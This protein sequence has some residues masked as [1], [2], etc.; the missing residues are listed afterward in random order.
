MLDNR[1][2]PKQSLDGGWAT[3][4]SQ[5]EAVVKTQS[6]NVF[7]CLGTAVAGFQKAHEISC[8]WRHIAV[9]LYVLDNQPR[10][11]KIFQSRTY[12]LENRATCT[13]AIVDAP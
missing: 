7:F 12:R 9:S 11:R 5:S 1:F 6:L 2:Y 8:E 13:A 3:S 4:R 10:R